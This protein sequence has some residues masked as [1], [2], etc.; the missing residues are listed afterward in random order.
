MKPT[1][2]YVK[3]HTKTGLKYFGKTTRKD[4]IKYKGSGLYWKRHLKKHGNF[5]RTTWLKLFEN[6]EELNEYAIKFSEEN[7]I[8]NSSEWANMKNENGLDGGR[9]PGFKGFIPSEE[10]RKIYSER[11][12]KNNPMFD[13]EI[14]KKHLMKMGESDFREKITLLKKG[15]TNVRGK[16]WYNNGKIT[17]MFKTPPDTSWIKGRLNPHWNTNRK[18]K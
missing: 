18:G 8:V 5:V 15:N 2:L 12:K 3:E 7:D 17:K 10:I 6:E 11:M 16:S 13:E 1:Y 14:R 4:P 9:D